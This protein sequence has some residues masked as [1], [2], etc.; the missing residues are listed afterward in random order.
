[1]AGI[2]GLDVT[3][4]IYVD[5]SYYASRFWSGHIRYLCFK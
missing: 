5:D 3:P 4:E 2:E 1:V